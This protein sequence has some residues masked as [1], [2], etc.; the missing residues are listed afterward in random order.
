MSRIF[1][2]FMLSLYA[3]SGWLAPAQDVKEGRTLL[4]REEF[5][6]RGALTGGWSAVRRAGDYSNHELQCYKPS[7]L[8]VA[9]GALTIASKVQSFLCGDA[10]HPKALFDYTSDMIQWTTFSFTYGTVEVHAKTAGGQ[11]SWPA[12]WMLGADCQASN[13]LT[14]DNI[15][16]CNWPHAGS[17]EIDI[18]EV[19][20]SNY[21]DVYH[22]LFGE[23]SYFCQQNT[24]DT[25]Q[26]WHL[27]TMTWAP[28]L[29]TFAIDQT[30]ASC[31]FTM[32]VPSTPM[33]LIINN[34]MGGLGGPVNST[35]F[36]QNML[37]D[38]VRVYAP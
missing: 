30:P 38:Y 17:E 16:T 29:I 26:N 11:G 8:S 24:S 18:L 33:F 10:D 31:S 25:S 23:N 7:N 19:A 2:I 34:A 36:P 15:G 22:N 3:L 28:G 37:I 14:A 35:D 5:G 1:K 32:N 20:N 27:Y 13:L 4:F 21:T 6:E 12:I 9:N